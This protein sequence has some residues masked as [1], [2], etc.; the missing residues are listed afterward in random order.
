MPN[1]TVRAAAEG[2][3]KV[4]RRA[5]H[6]AD[7]LSFMRIRTP[8]G[9]GIHYWHVET[10][11]SYVA[12]YAKGKALGREYLNYIGKHPTVGNSNLLGWIV[13]DMVA[14]CAGKLTG[15]ELGFLREVSEY[16]LVVASFGQ[17]QKGGAA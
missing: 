10:T 4:N 9:S 6:P 17:M 1:I 11:G 5:P 16:A 7:D 8:K 3:P 14:L 2:M 12:D 13:N 15:T